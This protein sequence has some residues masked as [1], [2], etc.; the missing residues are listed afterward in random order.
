MHTKFKCVLPNVEDTVVDPLLM[1]VFLVIFALS[2]AF[3]RL[4]WKKIEKLNLTQ[5]NDFDKWMA[6]GAPVC[7]SK[8][9]TNF[10]M[11]RVKEQELKQGPSGNWSVK[12][13]LLHTHYS[14]QYGDKGGDNKVLCTNHWL[15][16][17]LGN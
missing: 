9:T 11:F 13:D 10:L 4:W 14:L 12:W 16:V 17:T 8:Y 7:W 3:F 5:K 15:V 2:F 6:C 1:H